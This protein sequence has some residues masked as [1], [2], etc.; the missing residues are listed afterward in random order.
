MIGP[1]YTLDEE[2]GA[3]LRR[4]RI[5]SCGWSMPSLA[6]ESGV[7]RLTIF[8]IEHGSDPQLSTLLKL[9][10]AMGMTLSELVGDEYNG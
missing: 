6:E 2:F 5:E 1:H 3:R 4:L 7:H 9:S 8:G 10:Q